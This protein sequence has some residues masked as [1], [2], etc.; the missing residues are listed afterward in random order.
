MSE[1][2]CL[3]LL[4]TYQVSSVVRNSHVTWIKLPGID[5]RFYIGNSTDHDESQFEIN[6]R[7]EHQRDERNEQR[8]L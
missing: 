4:Y 3:T 5:E 1:C 6:T 7:A 8:P 2:V